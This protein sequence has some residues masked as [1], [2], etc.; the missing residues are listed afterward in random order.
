MIIRRVAS[1]AARGLDRGERGVLRQPDEV[2][3]LYTYMIHMI[4]VYIYIY[5]YTHTY[6]YTYIYIYIYMYSNIYIYIYIERERCIT[7]Y[8]WYIGGAAPARWGPGTCHI[9]PPTEIDRG[10]LLAF[11]Q[12]RKG[13]VY[14][15]EL[16]E[17]VKY[18]KLPARWGPV[19]ANVQ[20]KNP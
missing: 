5:A 17:R 16:A 4:Y 3:L 6:M 18:V 13:S 15:T 12:V 11:S 20:T 1:A 7:I 14:F 19:T 9:L 2:L 10:L 8:R